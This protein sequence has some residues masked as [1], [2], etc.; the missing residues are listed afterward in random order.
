M[1]GV[2]ARQY[3]E[4]EMQDPQYTGTV[5]DEVRACVRVHGAW[6]SRLLLLPPLALHCLRGCMPLRARPCSTLCG[7]HRP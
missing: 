6:C 2:G 4:N 7:A 1:Y 3:Y 5:Q